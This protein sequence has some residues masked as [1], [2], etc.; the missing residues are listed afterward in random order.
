MR[1]GERN[2]RRDNFLGS[3]AETWTFRKPHNLHCGSANC[4]KAK[5]NLKKKAPRDQGSRRQ[6]E[7]WRNA[8][9]IMHK[10]QRN[11]RGAKEL[12]RTR[13]D[14]S[15]TTTPFRVADPEELATAC[16]DVG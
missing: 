8:V 14:G 4:I 10:H 5:R 11:S 9:R 7:I 13:D 16:L 2:M 1:M 12:V 15:G 6:I 3:R